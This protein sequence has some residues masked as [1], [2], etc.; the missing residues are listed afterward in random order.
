[1]GCVEKYE[2]KTTTFQDVLVVEST[3]T[4]EFKR[5]EVKLSRAIP[6]DG[7]IPDSE[8]NAIVK[9]TT[10][11]GNTYDFEEV[12]GGVYKSIN[13]FK[14]EPNIFY[15]LTIKTEDDQIYESTEEMLTPINQIGDI[16]TE[17]VENGEVVGVRTFIN[18][19]IDSEAK[20][21]RYEYE[22][23]YK[24][25]TPYSVTKETQIGGIEYPG[26]CSRLK[27]VIVLSDL[28]NFDSKHICYQTNNNTKIL[29]KDNLTTDF[30][31]NFITSSDFKLRERYSILVKQY[32]LTKQNYL[33]YEILKKM[34]SSGNILAEI[35]KGYFHSNISGSEDKVVGFF[36]VNSVS[37]KRIYFNYLDFNFQQPNY[38]Y[39][40][41][42]TYTYNYLVKNC[43]PGD[44]EKERSLIYQKL[45]ENYPHY[46]VLTA[47]NFFPYLLNG[48]Y[49][50]APLIVTLVKPE[51]GNCTNFSSNIRP[52][53]WQD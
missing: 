53:W 17:K 19:S 11:N 9:I 25:V 29:L 41:N 32:V 44:G 8:R 36:G 49:I 18:S 40:C 20:Y 23:T 15:K 31:I 6:I 33:F 4:N 12:E 52:D 13:A 14:A 21:F 26:D 5:Q 50:Y 37:Y 42:E 3:I 27:Y 7:S 46:E 45:Y 2:P 22:E 16:H 24:I 28:E 38:L 43:L 10:S 1:M 34:R 51:C 39:F 35:Q 30:S 48:Q 47:S